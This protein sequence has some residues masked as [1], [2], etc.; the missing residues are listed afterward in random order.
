MSFTNISLV[1]KHISEHHLGVFEMENH[2]IQLEGIS[3]VKLPDSNIQAGSEKVKGKEILSPAQENISFSSG[4]I[5]QLLH[6][7]LIMDTVVVASD[8]SL[9][10]VFVENIDYSID[11]DNGKL[12]RIL[13]GSIPAFSSVAIFYLHYRIYQKGVDYQLDYSQGELVRTASGAIEDGQW[14]LLDY[15]V[16]YGFLNDETFAQAIVE[17]NER[18]IKFIDPSYY[19]SED[20][21]LVTAET[22]LSVSILCDVKAVEVLN[23][24]VNGASAQLLSKSWN[25]MAEVYS[26]K[27]Y[28][29]LSDF[30]RI[31]SS[32]LTPRAVKS[33]N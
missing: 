6:P 27:A 33:E 31:S 20:Q 2:P 14:V 12:S 29:V 7:E 5:I 10:K 22:Y 25:M 19:E 1:K 11:Y 24:N 8:S 26:N 3:P 18:V 15:K 17:A 28:L 32:L 4:D 30:A 16:E 9:R 21:G 23:L 13:T